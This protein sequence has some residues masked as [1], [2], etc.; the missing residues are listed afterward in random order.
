VWDI[1]EFL[2]DT[3]DFVPEELSRKFLRISSNPKMLLKLLS[4]EG[5]SSE[6][7]QSLFLNV[8]LKREFKNL[9]VNQF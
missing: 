2:H 1:I 7:G 8:V 5:I 3:V 9:I 6:Y 4:P